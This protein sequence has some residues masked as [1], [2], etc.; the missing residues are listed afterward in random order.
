MPPRKAAP[1]GAEAEAP[2]RSTRISALPKEEVKP[3]AKAPAKP[4]A[5]TKRSAEDEGSDAKV[6][7]KKVRS[8][9]S[10]MSTG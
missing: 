8:P 6:A 2:R 5:T 3:A 4:K 1:S 7:P 10:S 9:L